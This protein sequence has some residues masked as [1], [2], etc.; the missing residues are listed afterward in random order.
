M[1]AVKQ[2]FSCFYIYGLQYPKGASST[3]EFIQRY[4]MKIHPDQGTKSQT[5][6]NSKR[7]VLSLM[8][9]LANFEMK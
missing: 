6:S 8:K 1:E 2:C 9:L 3:W 7:K 4:F 5:F